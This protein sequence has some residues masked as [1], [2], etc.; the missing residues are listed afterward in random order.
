M[1]PAEAAYRQ[2]VAA[3]AVEV[4]VDGADALLGHVLHVVTRPAP[5]GRVACNEQ[6]KGGWGVGG[7]EG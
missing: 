6:E 7:K 4:D 2:V 3:P 5:L 1:A